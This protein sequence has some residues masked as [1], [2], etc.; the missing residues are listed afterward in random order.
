M[1]YKWNPESERA[2]LLSAITKSDY[3]PST[4]IWSAVADEMGSGL[5]ANACQ[6]ALSTVFETCS[7]Y[8]RAE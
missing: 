7:G 6:Y 4:Q 1:P 5:N 3:K 8:L 2:L